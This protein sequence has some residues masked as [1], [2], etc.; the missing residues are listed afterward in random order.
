M[1]GKYRYSTPENHWQRFAVQ[2]QMYRT[3]FQEARE[4]LEVNFLGKVPVPQ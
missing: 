4:V 2:L 1:Y 3:L